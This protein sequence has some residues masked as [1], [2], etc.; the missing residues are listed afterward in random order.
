MCTVLL[1]PVVNPITINV[2]MN[3]TFNALAVPS[4]L[5]GSEHVS[6]ERR[7]KRLTSI[8]MERK[9]EKKKKTEILQELKL[10]PVNEK[11][12]RLNQVAYDM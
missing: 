6:L 3:I 4:L 11:L 8:E 7:T 2:Y 10:E 9:R 12:R 1:S 5:Y